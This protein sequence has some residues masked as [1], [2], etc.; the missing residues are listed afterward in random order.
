[1]A[2]A[3]KRKLRELCTIPSDLQETLTASN[4]LENL[5]PARLQVLLAGLL[6]RGIVYNTRYSGVGFFECAMK[7]VVDM[8]QAGA[9]SAEHVT[10]S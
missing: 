10:A 5:P 6:D 8:L 3:Q 1:M 4:L 9:T 7:R 2:Q